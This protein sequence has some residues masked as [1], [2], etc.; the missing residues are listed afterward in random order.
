MGDEQETDNSS[1]DS[2]IYGAHSMSEKFRLL[3]KH[4]KL[5]DTSL[6]WINSVNYLE[7]KHPGRLISGNQ[8]MTLKDVYESTVAQLVDFSVCNEI[9]GL[10]D[11]LK[12][13]IN[14]DHSPSDNSILHYI[15][16]KYATNAKPA[17]I[18]ISLDSQNIGRKLCIGDETIKTDA[19]SNLAGR[20][21]KLFG[22]STNIIFFVHIPS[23]PHR[24][25]L[26]EKCFNGAFM[27][28]SDNIDGF[29]PC[30]DECIRS[31][32]D[33][34][35]KLLFE[36]NLRSQSQKFVEILE[37]YKKQLQMLSLLAAPLEKLT[38]ALD[39]T[40]EH[41]QRLR[42]ILY[43]PSRAIFAASPRVMM[44]FEE[45][46]QLGQGQLSWEAVHEPDT[47]NNVTTLRSVRL[48]L[49][50]VI[51][52]IFGKMSPWPEN[53]GAL[54]SRAKE[55]LTSPP[56]GGDEFAFE[57]LRKTCIGLIG[58]KNPFDEQA[59]YTK[60]ASRFKKVL[61]RPFKD[62]DAKYPLEPLLVGLYGF[63]TNLK[64][65]V[66]RGRSD[67]IA[68]FYTLQDALSE[69][70]KIGFPLELFA[71]VGLP[72][73]RY[74]H[75]L[76]LLFGIIAFAKNEQSDSG[77]M[78][79]VEV[80]IDSDSVSIV[81]TFKSKIFADTGKLYLTMQRWLG[82]RDATLR[83]LGNLYKPFVDFVLL[84]EGEGKI[85]GD[86][87]S[88]EHEGPGDTKIRTCIAVKGKVFRYSSLTDAKQEIAPLNSGEPTL[89][90]PRVAGAA[91]A[92]ACLYF[93]HD[94]NAFAVE[95]KFGVN[96]KNWIRITDLPEF[97]EANEWSYSTMQE[98]S[99]NG[100][101]QKICCFVHDASTMQRWIDLAK[102]NAGNIYV[103]FVSRSSLSK[104]DDW[105]DNVDCHGS[106]VAN[107]DEDSLSGLLRDAF[108]YFVER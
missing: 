14:T 33:W 95:D 52:E 84:A 70:D 7:L 21:S 30:V 42:S 103:V 62:G 17:C 66:K 5:N 29:H 79:C 82:R 4:F 76:A 12:E 60:A 51:C 48:T 36:E 78:E 61:Y 49:A 94:D 24:S 81:V 20:Y 13:E 44:Y 2:I 27:A 8:D 72:V 26:I 102:Q 23:P 73:P 40:I 37:Q 99:Y 16:E 57:Q 32:L 65:E 46:R 97:K 80:Q 87:F 107:L 47:A 38:D 93:N 35:V 45:G 105:P 1:L 90:Q 69:L 10:F 86:G 68:A 83:Y 63:K 58:D 18:N 77:E 92:F 56:A 91:Q 28:F 41:T 74:A 9:T 104:Q 55:L 11:E 53:E 6:L 31:F 25:G 64:F 96:G 106:G 89:P 71:N 43:D 15:E 19:A 54:I 98:A 34:A 85:D 108:G 39:E 75:W 67:C 59:M 50:A 101:V 22:K 3:A 100:S 88:I